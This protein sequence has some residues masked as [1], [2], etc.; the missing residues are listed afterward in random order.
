MKPILTDELLQLLQKISEHYQPPPP[1]GKRGRRQEFF[2]QSFLLLAVVA[3][4]TKTFADSELFRLLQADPQLLATCGFARVPHR[5]TIVRRLKSLTAAA[6]RQISLTGTTIL[7]TFVAADVQTV[8]AI[9]GRMYQA[10]GPRWHKK[11]R[12]E[13][14]IPQGLRNVNRESEWFKSGYRGWVQGYRLVLQSLVFPCPVPLSA[15]WTPNSFGESTAAKHVVS[16]G[17]LVKTAVLLGDETFGGK[18]LTDLY[19]QHGGWLLTPKQLPKK[20]R[21]FKHDLYDYRKET[22]ELLFQRIIQTFDLKTC[23]VKGLHKNGAFI[24]AC[25]WVYQI[26]CLMNFRESKPLFVIKELIEAARWRIQL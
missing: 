17:Q 20:R 12:R 24:L 7:E 16:N 1:I 8:S 19:R 11:H 22:I 13:N 4:V 14:L 6:E 5:T 26:V 9:D 25:V 18:D 15:C 3:I 10:I 21:S 23:Q 2:E